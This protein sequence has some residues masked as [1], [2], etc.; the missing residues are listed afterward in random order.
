[1]N[2][3]HLVHAEFLW[4]EDHSMRFKVRLRVQKEVHNGAIFEQSYVVVYVVQDQLCQSCFRV[5]ANP[6]QWVAVVQL[7]QHVSYGRT[8]FYLEQLILT[9][10]AAARAIR[11]KQIDNGID[12]F[13][14]I[15]VME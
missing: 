12:F 8:F 9:H 15:G 1:M 5:H 7:R 11:I 2:K 10:G 3:V 6:D 4:C 13:L 14:L